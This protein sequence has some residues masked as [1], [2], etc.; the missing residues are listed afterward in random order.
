MIRF[1]EPAFGEKNCRFSFWVINTLIAYVLYFN[2][3]Y[4]GDVVI[5]HDRDRGLAIA[6]G[7]LRDSAWKRMEEACFTMTE[8]KHYWYD[9]GFWEY[10]SRLL[11]IIRGREK[12]CG[13]RGLCGCKATKEDA[14][15]V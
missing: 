13:G 4:L 12:L 5:H 2:F 10:P 8:I 14:G 6:D 3:V 9:Q 7:L 1:S 15:S 11:V